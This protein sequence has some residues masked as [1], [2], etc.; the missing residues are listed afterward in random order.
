MRQFCFVVIL[1]VLSI[2]AGLV[3]SSSENVDNLV[4]ASSNG[5]DQSD[6]LECGNT[7]YGNIKLT[8]NL[9]C[10]SDGLLVIS[11]NGLTIDLNGYSIIGPG[12]KSGKIGINF[13]DS[14]DIQII[15]NGTIENYQVGINID[16]SM[17][18]DISHLTF[19]DN[20]LGVFFTNSKNSKLSES[21]L[22]TNVIGTSTN[23]ARNI[24]IS[25][26]TYTLNELGGIVMVNSEENNISNNKVNGSVNGIFLDGQ[27]TDNVIE[28]NISYQ[29]R[30]VDINNGNGLPTDINDNNFITNK[31]NTS[32][33]GGLCVD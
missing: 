7:I 15:G 21:N 5:V 30:G 3:Y 24:V 9:D 18:I 14:E 26:N 19:Q 6:N 1:P 23:T 8:E 2:F 10:I 28:D 4:L 29:N 16:T 27:S 31:C 20:E 33:P 17:G 12:E 22:Q 32:V 11:E 25:N 13:R